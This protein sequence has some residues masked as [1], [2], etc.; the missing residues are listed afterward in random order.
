M[1]QDETTDELTNESSSQS[2]GGLSQEQRMSVINETFAPGELSKDQIDIL[3]EMPDD[4]FAKVQQ[5]GILKSFNKIPEDILDGL[6]KEKEHQEDQKRRWDVI[7]QMAQQNNS[8]HMKAEK[9]QNISQKL[10]DFNKDAVKGRLKKSKVLQKYASKLTEREVKEMSDGSMEIQIDKMSKAMQKSYMALPEDIRKNPNLQ[11]VM[12]MV[13]NLGF[14]TLKTLLKN[15]SLLTGNWES[16]S[17]QEWK[18]ML[19]GHTLEPEKPK[20]NP[21]ALIK[22]RS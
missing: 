18:A 6:K 21:Q 20:V 3:K 22:D 11:A 15:P 14:G 17:P 5:L 7:I 16:R 19:N 12:S 8:F 10:G 1:D 13:N 2:E 9:W 4:I